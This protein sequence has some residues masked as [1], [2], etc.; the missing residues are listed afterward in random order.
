MNTFMSFVF[1]ADT[2]RQ[3]LRTAWMTCY[4]FEFIDNKVIGGVEKSLP[5]VSEI[6]KHIERKA[7]GKITS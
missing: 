5:A 6:I 1:N 7:T 3:H 4:D 2:L